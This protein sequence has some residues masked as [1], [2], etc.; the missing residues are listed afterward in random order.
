LHPHRSAIHLPQQVLG[1][2]G[3][4][5]DEAGFQGLPSAH[6]LGCF[7][8]SLRQPDG[9]W[10]PPLRQAADLSFQDLFDLLAERLREI[11]PLAADGGSSSDSGLWG[12]PR[13]VSSQ[14]HQRPGGPG[15]GSPRGHI[16]DHRDRALPDHG[17][18][19]QGEVDL[20]ARGAEL[21][22]QR[23]R[24]LILSG[25]YP[26]PQVIRHHRG[27]CPLHPQPHHAGS[28]VCLRALGSQQQHQNPYPPHPAK[29]AHRNS[30]L[31]SVFGTAW[32]RRK[33]L[34]QPSI[35]RKGASAPNRCPHGNS[36]HP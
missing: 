30:F 19:A 6:R 16:D 23:L 21:Q 8:R 24:P 1:A 12:H 17:D 11:L 18:Q 36:D 31:V 3:D 9:V 13:Q 29:S 20:P 15:D 27:Q 28:G 34:L 33:P 26:P 4:P 25:L 5:I 32:S 35:S 22:H 10:A 7:H 14:G 2:L